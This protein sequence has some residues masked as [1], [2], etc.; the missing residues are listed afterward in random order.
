MGFITGF[1][2]D[3]N[4]IYVIEVIVILGMITLLLFIFHSLGLLKKEK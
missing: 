2:R 3:M 1:F 4:Y